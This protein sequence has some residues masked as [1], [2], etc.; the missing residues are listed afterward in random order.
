MS[1]LDRLMSRKGLYATFWFFAIFMVTALIYFTANLQ[2]EVPPIPKVVVSEAGEVLY[3]YDDVIEG[4]GYFQQFDLMDWGTL[5]GMGAYIGPDFTTDFMHKRAE[6]LYDFY[7]YQMY[8]KRGKDLTKIE[9]GAVKERVKQDFHQ[10]TALNEERVVYTTAS[11]EAYKKNVEY[12]VDLLVNGD[13]ERAFTGGVIRPDEAR[14][15]AAFIDWSQ[16]VASSLRPGTDRTWSNDW[17]PEPLVDQGNSWI[18]NYYS[19]WEFLLLWTLT[20][21]VI[22]LSYEYLFKKDEHDQLSEPMKI[23]S[24]FPSQK[25][26]LKYVP[27]VA[28]LF[29]V[30]LIIGGYLSHLYTEPSKDFIISQEILPFNV[31]RSIH[32]QLAILWVAVG[33]LVGG[34]L[35]APWVANKDHKFPWLV[36]VLWAALVVVAVGGIIGLYMGATG[37]MRDVWFWFG[38]EGRELINLGRFWDIGLVVGLVFWFLLVISLIRKAATNNPLVST[39]IWSAFAIATL[40]MAGMMPL[41]KIMPNFTV[42]DYY[43]WWVIHLWVELTF[44]LFAA[45]SLAFFTVSLG[46]VSHKVAVKTMLF[47][48]ALIT[49]S[50]TLGVGHHYWWQGLDQYWIAIGGIFSA[51]EP[52]PL[53]LLMIE[54][55]KQQRELSASES[56]F[57][58][59]TV[60]MWLAG[61]AFLN[62]IGAGFLG[63]V[64]NTPTI[65]YYSHGTYLIMP[66]GHVAL[67]GAFGYISLAFIYMTARTNS[68]ANNLEWNDTLTKWGFWLLT[69]GVLLFAIPTIVIGFHQAEIAHDFGYYYARLREAVEPLKGWLW[70]RIIPDSM[71]ILGGALVLFDLVKKMYFSK[72]MA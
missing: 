20:I 52:L 12:L 50:G 29:L 1:L 34:L 14:K 41:H 69:I 27:I 67:L 71:M 26:L 62:W 28:G 44:E 22:F 6:S 51:L 3:T 32:T 30:Q 31:L 46:L 21:L 65:N 24:I 61:S 2:K 43:R 59:N 37:Q 7:G 45:G 39:I 8:G 49:M 57:A 53:A 72:K 56:G 15:I 5:L 23:T 64:I 16:L 40:Y 17:P 13:R 63:M 10:E 68:L 60:F 66:H 4:K 58:F 48:L 55:W 70:I 25:K 19:L 36:D 42:D 18:N 9:R 54:A 47:E 35:I 38:N 33:W 11:A